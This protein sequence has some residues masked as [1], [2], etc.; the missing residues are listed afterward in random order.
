MTLRAENPTQRREGA[1]TAE[2]WGVATPDFYPVI[3]AKA[4]I[5]MVEAEIAPGNQV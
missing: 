3:P 5:Q 4:G 2:K 1:K